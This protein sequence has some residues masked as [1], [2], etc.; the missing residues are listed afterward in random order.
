MKRF[1]LLLVFCLSA[2]FAAWGQSFTAEKITLPNSTLHNFYRID[3]NVYRSEQPTAADFK[4]LE[5]Y[6]I[7]EVLNLRN[8]HSD[9]DAEGTDLVL[10]RVKTN[11]YIINERDFIK[12]LRIIHNRK[13]PIVFHCLHGSDRT[14]AICAMYRIVFQGV[15]KEDAIRELKEGGYGFHPVFINIIPAIRNADIDYIR[16]EVLK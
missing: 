7:R 2:L 3:S 10:H 6:G 1:L 8:W 5:K 12:A 15:S 14:G 16:S 4:A 13:G 9:K 11:A